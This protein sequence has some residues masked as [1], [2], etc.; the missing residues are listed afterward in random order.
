MLIT[1]DAPSGWRVDGLSLIMADPSCCAGFAGDSLLT[2]RGRAADGI[3]WV[4][5]G[6]RQEENWGNLDALWAAARGFRLRCL[7]LEL[8][9]EKGSYKGVDGLGDR[10]VCG[11]CGFGVLGGQW[12]CGWGCLYSVTGYRHQAGRHGTAAMPRERSE[13]VMGVRTFVVR[14]ARSG[15][16]SLKRPRR[17]GELRGLRLGSGCFEGEEP[18]PVV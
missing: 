17:A 13:V 11:R 7:V 1:V 18:L 6:Q 3:V 10:V 9:W 12:V 8:D 2:L 15:A 16:W 4:M 5:F 14:W